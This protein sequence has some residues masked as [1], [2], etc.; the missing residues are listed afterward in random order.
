MKASELLQAAKENISTPERWC[1]GTLARDAE[2]NSTNPDNPDAVSFCSRGSCNKIMGRHWM[3][4][5]WAKYLRQAAGGYVTV[6]NDN[7]SHPDVMAMFD[8]AIA[9]A[10]AD[11]TEGAPQV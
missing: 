11:E 3:S 6:F 7:H 10:Q 8:R 4:A 9:L 2:G 5:N 1:Q